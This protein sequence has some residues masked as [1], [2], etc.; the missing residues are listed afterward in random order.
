MSETGRRPLHP[1]WKVIHWV[2]IVNFAVQIAYGAYMVFVVV[3]PEGGGPLMDQ[4]T[5]FPFEQMMTRR[6]YASE[7]WIAIVGLSLYLAI[8]EIAPRLQAARG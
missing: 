1:V 8:T 5:T 3:A 6:L 4:A 7:T 2:I